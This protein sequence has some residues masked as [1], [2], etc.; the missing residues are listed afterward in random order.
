MNFPSVWISWIRTCISSSS[1][2]FLIN[3]QHS[4]WIHSTCGFR[5]GDP[6]SSYL[7]I[8]VS[9]ILTTKLNYALNRNYIPSFDSTLNINFNHLMYADDLILISHASRC[10]ARNFNLCLSMYDKLTGQHSNF[11]KLAVYLPTWFNRRVA[12]SIC[13]I[14]NFNQASFPISYLGVLITPKRLEIASFN[15]MI[16]TIRHICT[17]W[18]H[19]KL[20]QVAKVILINSS[21]LSIP[22]Y[23]T[24]VYPIPDTVLNEINKIVRD[25]LWYKDNNR[26]GIH[27]V[28]LSNLT[29]SKSEGGLGIKNLLVAKTSLMAKNI[30]K[31]LN[32]ED[33]F[34][35]NTLLH[36]HVKINFWKDPIPLR[37]S[38]FF[39][40]LLPN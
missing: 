16:S 15:P 34:W 32:A 21:I 37:Y 6:I 10:V 5:Q 38:W 31:F 30:L 23:Y 24:S 18:K 17:K 27:V 13:S 22:T 12:K 40:I 9:Q 1:F 33:T 25:F 19:S 14:L 26:K 2:S 4:S 35:V 28:A 29:D 8:L 39:V 11:N 7:F 36:K 20:S 3:V